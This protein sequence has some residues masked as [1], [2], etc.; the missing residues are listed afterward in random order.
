[1][2]P[3]GT[4]EHCQQAPDREYGATTS[5]EAVCGRPFHLLANG[6]EKVKVVG[7]GEIG[8]TGESAATRRDTP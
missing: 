5:V 4:E 6:F 7:N 3:G 8:K 1:M 2:R